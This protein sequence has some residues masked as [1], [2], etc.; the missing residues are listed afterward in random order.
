M[1]DVHVPQKSEH[2]WTDFFIHIGTIAVGLLL[3]IGLEQGVEFI[4]HR[5]QRHELQQQLQADA[6]KNLQDTEVADRMLTV[7]MHYNVERMD[8]VRASLEGRKLPD[9]PLPPAV[10]SFDT[11]QDP[12]WQAAKADGTVAVLPAEDIK[13]FTELDEIISQILP[14]RNTDWDAQLKVG[15]V[16]WTLKRD[17][18][19]DVDIESLTADQ[20]RA[21]LD[22]LLQEYATRRK[23]RSYLRRLRGGTLAVAHGERDLRKVQLAEREFLSLP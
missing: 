21:Y 6:E 2:T 18:T 20:K 5:H 4:H 19:H 13:V 23:L 3:A 1:I 16:E 10:A 8:Q 7:R 15:N 12:A 14:L 9:P 17:E 11:P 22:A